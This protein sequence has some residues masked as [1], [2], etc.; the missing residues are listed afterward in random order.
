MPIILV[1]STIDKIWKIYDLILI[2]ILNVKSLQIELKKKERRKSTKFHRVSNLHKTKFSILKREK[3]NLKARG[4]TKG[5]KKSLE[6]SGDRIIDFEIVEIWS[7]TDY[8]MI[9][10]D[11]LSARFM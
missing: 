1:S 3:R 2:L 7:A 10:A 8:D 4:E 9:R 11:P 5:M 6:H